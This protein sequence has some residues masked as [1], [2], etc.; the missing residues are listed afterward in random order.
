MFESLAYRFTVN[1]DNFPE[2]W[3]PLIYLY[4]PDLPLFPIY[5]FHV[6]PDNLAPGRRPSDSE[7]A[8][9]YVERINWTPETGLQATIIL[10]KDLNEPRNNR[11]LNNVTRE[12]KER[13]GIINPVTR[14]DINNVFT[15]RLNR[16]NAILSELW[17]RVIATAYGDLLPFGRLWDEV[18]GLTRF[19]ASW[20]SPGGR[21]GE[22]IQT[23]YF[24]SKFGV[25]I[26][27]SGDVPQIDFYLLPTIHELLDQTNP[28]TSFRN[29]SQLLNIA[30]RIQDH[31]CTFVEVGGLQ[32]SRFNNPNR[33]R[34]RAV[35]LV[36]IFN[37]TAISPEDKPLAIECFN[38]FDKGPQR[39]LIFLL[40]LDDLRK[41][42]LNPD[43]LTS[44]QS[45]SI[46]DGLNLTY[47]SPKVIEIY[48]QQS[49]GNVDAMPIDTWIKTMFK[50]P[51]QVY[52]A[53]NSP[54]KITQIFSNS[55]NLGKAE[56][57]LWVVAQ[58]RKVHSSACNDAVWCIKYSG[59]KPRGANPLACNICLANIRNNCPAY[60]IIRN[61]T[62][63]FNTTGG[64]FVITTSSG[65]NTTNNQTFIKCI[66]NSIYEDI[67]DEFSPADSPNGFAPFPGIGHDGS[68]LTV[69]DFIQR[70]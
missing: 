36:A 67:I 68:N 62:V 30:N 6:L 56:R 69:Q 49:F 50:W 8:Y 21:K 18:L 63:S 65:N 11:Y 51:L 34:F 39:P 1:I 38:A 64:H 7:R 12:V 60:N 13:F 66:G 43:T 47:Q 16:S 59:N 40:M 23:H 4:D 27:S 17:E 44:E 32:L 70:Y 54:N 37:G 53:D 58:S 48:A 15:G 55:N 29:Y 14:A 26:Q 2:R 28:L 10:N 9:G 31:Y 5:Y 41:G 20:N 3:L 61:F 33:G 46:Y 35:D 19:V 52:P 25:P 42:R 45:G 22:F 24:A 57:L